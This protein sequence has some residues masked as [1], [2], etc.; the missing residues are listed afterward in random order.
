MNSVCRAVTLAARLKALGVESV[1]A[2]QN[3]QVGDNWALRY[4][5][6]RFHV[7]TAS[8]EMPYLRK[9]ESASLHLHGSSQLT[10]KP[11]DRL[12]SGTADSAPSNQRRVS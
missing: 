11:G 5:C 6:M 4:D 12:P 7:S 1:M 10:P 3:A 9:Q 8:C 2:E